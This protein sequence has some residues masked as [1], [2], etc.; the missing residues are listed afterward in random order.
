LRVHRDG[1]IEVRAPNFV[2]QVILRR[3]VDS[4]A[5]W[6]LEKQRYFADLLKNY[7]PKEFRNGETFPVLG[8]N[9]RLKVEHETDSHQP[10]CRLDSRRLKVIVNGESG[11]Q[12]QRVLRRSIR[13]WYAALTE[14]KVR[15]VI[16]KHARALAVH[17]G[18]L[19]IADQAKRWASCSKSGDIRCNW[20]LSM[21]PMP[22]LEYVVTHE[23]C[24]LR[25]H[26]HSAQFWRTLKSVLPDYE[27]RR[28]WLKE[29]GGPLECM[30]GA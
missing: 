7:P 3:F 29:H 5:E 4:R 25:T 11:E 28:D 6:I 22:V 20:R 8:R 23:L 1:E 21:M 13:E 27:K 26:D 9:H 19:K 15:A 2:K 10:I 12:L 14:K 16:R 18:K 30:F 24:H 17:P